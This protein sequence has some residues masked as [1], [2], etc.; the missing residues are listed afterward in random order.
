MAKLLLLRGLPASGKSTY[1]R[2]LVNCDQPAW[3]RINWDEQRESLWGGGPFT[4]EKE[5]KMQDATMEM[6][7]HYLK[8][9]VNVVVDNTNLNQKTVVSWLGLASNTDSKFEVLDIKTPIEE[10][11]RRDAARD[12]KAHVGRPVI[13]RMALFS[14]LIKFEKP[15]AI[16]DLDG[17]LCDSEW[18]VQKYLST[19]PKD[20]DGFYSE[21]LKD[22]VRHA[23]AVNLL[24]H[25]Q[26]GHEII[27]LTGRPEDKCWRHTRIWLEHHSIRFDHIFMRSRGDKR[28]DVVVKGEYMQKIIEL[29]GIEKIKVVYE[30]RPRVVRAWQ[31]MGLPVIDVGNGVEF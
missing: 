11:I 13:E 19:K 28:E 1:A 18:R 15:L 27:I 14:G 30:D 22:D 26:E 25:Q 31:E 8:N 12:G 17:T 4:K 3:V 20:W 16:F 5:R 23:I 2:N 21:I 7:A 9:G 29:A 10:C 6:A 24:Y